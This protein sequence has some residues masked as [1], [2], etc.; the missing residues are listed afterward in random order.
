MTFRHAEHIE[1]AYADR[2]LGTRFVLAEPV[3]VTP[4]D[5]SAEPCWGQTLNVSATGVSLSTPCPLPIGSPVKL[6]VTDGMILGEVRYCHSG[7]ASPVDY[8]LGLSI[9][10]VLF[11]WKEFYERARALDI[12][13]EDPA[14]V[15]Q[16]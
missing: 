3:K 2:R 11:G 1:K 16:A 5:G 7:P 12:V 10:H 13:V 15:A 14:D 9:E 8:L 4:L 6:E